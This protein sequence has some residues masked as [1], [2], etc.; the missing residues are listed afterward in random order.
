MTEQTNNR[1]ETKEQKAAREQLEALRAQ[2]LQAT[3]SSG[4]SSKLEGEDK[5]IADELQKPGHYE[6][7]GKNGFYHVKWRG[8]FVGVIT[9]DREKGTYTAL[10]GEKAFSN[11]Q[12]AAILLV[13][14][15]RDKGLVEV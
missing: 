12:E 1:T 3:K 13:K 4:S 2:Y 7:Q 15:A 11:R 6:G 5:K 14:A 10:P 9:M 8:E